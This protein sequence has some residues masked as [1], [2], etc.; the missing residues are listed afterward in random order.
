[1]QQRKPERVVAINNLVAYS[2]RNCGRTLN[3]RVGEHV[4]SYLSENNPR[5][6]GKKVESYAGRVKTP[7]RTRDGLLCGDE[8]QEV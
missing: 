1:M 7:E 2:K 6:R 4:T 5:K 3:T 8:W